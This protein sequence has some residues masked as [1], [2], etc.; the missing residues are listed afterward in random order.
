MKQT[1]T[2]YAIV[3]SIGAFLALFASSCGTMSKQTQSLA[4]TH[5]ARN[6]NT[7]CAAYN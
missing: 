6:Y 4:G 1:L 7:G 3:A 2:R 5:F